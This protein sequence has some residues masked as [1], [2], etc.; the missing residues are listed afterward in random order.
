MPNAIHRMQKSVCDNFDGVRLIQLAHFGRLMQSGVRYLQVGKIARS[1][2]VTIQA[3]TVHLSVPICFTRLPG[4]QHSDHDHPRKAKTNAVKAM[5]PNPEENALAADERIAFL[6][7]TCFS[8]ARLMTPA[9]TS[10]AGDAPP[11]VEVQVS[12][13]LS[14]E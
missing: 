1:V 6:G 11:R 8:A 3:S 12:V 4:S 5:L 10:A 13:E 9:G 7:T 14:G 2:V